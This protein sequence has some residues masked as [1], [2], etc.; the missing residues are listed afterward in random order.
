V[1]EERLGEMLAKP[2][3]D[4][5]RVVATR[6]MGAMAEDDMRC[7][8]QGRFVIPQRFRDDLK[9]K[10]EVVVVGGVDRVEIWPKKAH[11]KFAADVKAKAEEMRAMAIDAAVSPQLI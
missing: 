9:L 7:D 1:W 11:E 2:A 6:H 4:L 8:A 5:D 10:G 3:G